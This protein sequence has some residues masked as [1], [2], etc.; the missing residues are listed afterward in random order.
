MVCQLS[1]S[2]MLS[3]TLAL[4][5]SFQYSL[6]LPDVNLLSLG[7]FYY[8]CIIKRMNGVYMCDRVISIVLWSWNETKTSNI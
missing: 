7:S 4:L 1:L 2:K 5:E 6:L 3:D 8:Y